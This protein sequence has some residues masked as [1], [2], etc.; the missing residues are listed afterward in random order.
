MKQ[1]GSS[2]GYG[3]VNFV[4]NGLDDSELGLV[5]LAQVGFFEVI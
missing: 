2:L 4:S 1:P 3:F 5:V